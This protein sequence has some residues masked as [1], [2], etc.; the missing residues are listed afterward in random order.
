MKSTLK[1]LSVK[2]QNAGSSTGNQWSQ[3][4][5]KYIKSFSP[6]DGTLIGEVSLTTNEEY[7]DIVSTALEAQKTWQNIPAPQRGEI[8][9]QMGDELRKH[10]ASV[11]RIGFVSK[12]GNRCKK[13][14][15]KCKR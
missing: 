4:S 1:Q 12:W 13:V 11:G 7:Q 15:A 3:K 14:W 5:K 9:R 8:V 10:K 6:V 2:N